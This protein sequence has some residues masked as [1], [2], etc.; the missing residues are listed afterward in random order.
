MSTFWDRQLAATWLTQHSKRAKHV[1]VVLGNSDHYGSSRT[2]LLEFWRK[3]QDTLPN[4]HILFGESIMIEGVLFYGDTLWCDIPDI[5]RTRFANGQRKIYHED[6][7]QWHDEAVNK[8]SNFLQNKPA[9]ISCVVISHYLPSEKSISPYFINSPF[10]SM[11]YTNLER[12]MCK[13]NMILWLH[14]HT[15]TQ[16][17]YILN[18]TRVLCNPRGY[19]NERLD[20]YAPLQISIQDPP[21][22]SV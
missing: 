2:Q 19:V 10:N 17:D 5:Y 11:F 15:H 16:T 14:G 12:F 20:S 22:S 8:L 7:K 13:K 6:I 21:P 3:F 4:V 1:V 9:N 18:G